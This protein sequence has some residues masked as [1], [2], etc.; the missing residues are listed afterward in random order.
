[1]RR[2]LFLRMKNFYP[3]IFFI[4]IITLTCCDKKNSLRKSTGNDSA[5][6]Y[7]SK[8]KLVDKVPDKVTFLNNALQHLEKPF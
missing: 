8:V 6:F 3:V 5:Y 7:F 4:L 1:M 2:F